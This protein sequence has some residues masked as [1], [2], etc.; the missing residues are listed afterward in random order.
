[1]SSRFRY[2]LLAFAL[3]VPFVAP[4]H[5]EDPPQNRTSRTRTCADLFAELGRSVINDE[6]LKP[7]NLSQGKIPEGGAFLTKNGV[8]IVRP[9]GGANRGEV[10]ILNEAD[11]AK[12]ELTRLLE[13]SKLSNREVVITGEL[14]LDQLVK[15]IRTFNLGRGVEQIY[16]STNPSGPAARAKQKVL[17]SSFKKVQIVMDLNIPS[18]RL[19]AAMHAV[20][21]GDVKP[22]IPQGPVEFISLRDLPGD[23]TLS[24]RLLESRA[25]PDTF[26]ITVT[27]YKPLTGEA[28]M[29]DGSVM[30]VAKMNADRIK[31]GTADV[32]AGC[33]L[34]P[35]V[36]GW[37][38]IDGKLMAGEF[39]ELAD[40]IA[41]HFRSTAMISGKD[42]LSEFDI[43]DRSDI[44]GWKDLTSGGNGGDGGNGGGDAII[45][46][47]GNGPGG[48][49]DGQSRPGARRR[50]SFRFLEI[51]AFAL[52]EELLREA[53]AAGCDDEKDDDKEKCK[54]GT[55]ILTLENSRSIIRVGQAS[56]AI[57]PDEATVQAGLPG[58]GFGGFAMLTTTLVPAGESPP[59]T[60]G[61]EARPD[62]DEPKS[63]WFRSVE[64]LVEIRRLIFPRALDR[65]TM[66]LD[67]PRNRILFFEPSRQSKLDIPTPVLVIALD[68][69][70]TAD[71]VAKLKEVSHRFWFYAGLE[72]DS[73]KTRKLLLGWQEIT[74]VT[75]PFIFLIDGERPSSASWTLL[76]PFFLNITHAGE[77]L[78]RN[79]QEA[80]ASGLFWCNAHHTEESFKRYSEF[81]ALLMADQGAKEIAL[82]GDPSPALAKLMKGQDTNMWL[83]GVWVDGG[84]KNPGGL[85]PNSRWVDTTSCNARIAFVSAY[86]I[87]APLPG[88]YYEVRSSKIITDGLLK[89][90]DLGQKDE[91]FLGAEETLN[92]LYKGLSERG[93]IIAVSSCGKYLLISE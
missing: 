43:F 93:G 25:P 50:A 12:E 81:S 61:S 19:A 8:V 75:L 26:R 84:L 2:L 27:H 13:T 47:G 36:N 14:P 57:G 88:M 17:S 58:L 59:Q 64:E 42:I 77:S 90:R 85:V 80:W 39:R 29:T 72:Q 35:E 71:Q 48:I 45:P 65:P 62:R 16:F 18:E 87:S 76:K 24:E 32:Y 86:P 15:T 66:L 46:P 74:G 33:N 52:A 83:A 28:L 38:V 34:R 1:M 56:K 53:K 51:I 11:R 4:A 63:R 9:A 41:S 68:A 22:L 31:T 79:Q 67:S 89:L 7:F 54:A 23:G 20:V 44:G 21:D 82:R 92:L 78:P 3:H 10:I 60:P 30:S 73:I 49:N 40:R 37:L 5:G 70:P 91:G 55:V 69:K 6:R